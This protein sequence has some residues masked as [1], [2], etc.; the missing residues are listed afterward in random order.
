[1]LG[2]SDNSSFYF[3][4]FCFSALGV[5][6]VLACASILPTLFLLE[7]QVVVGVVSDW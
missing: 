2:E 1:M 7:G 3:D 4:D 6:S 5:F